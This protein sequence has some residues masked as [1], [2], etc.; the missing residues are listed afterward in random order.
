M[1]KKI[2]VGVLITVLSAA[3]IYITTFVVHANTKANDNCYR[4]EDNEDDIKNLWERKAD[5]YDIQLIRKDL[6]Y[7]KKTL[8]KIED[9]L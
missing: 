4:I 2:L 6:D 8:D 3:V 1:R 5:N 7:I 9:K